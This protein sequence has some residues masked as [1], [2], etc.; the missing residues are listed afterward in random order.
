MATAFKGFFQ[1]HIADFRLGRTDRMLKR[2]ALPLILNL[3]NAHH[4]M[5]RRCDIQAALDRAR[6]EFTETTLRGLRLSFCDPTERSYRA[7]VGVR[8]DSIAG[9]PSMNLIYFL[10]RNRGRIAIEM[11]EM[12]SS[13]PVEKWYRAFSILPGDTWRTTGGH[14]Q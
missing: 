3:S 11:I 4:K 7:R 13:V 2:Y 8:Y 9:I 12:T 10:S 6:D 1:A 5:S 14:L